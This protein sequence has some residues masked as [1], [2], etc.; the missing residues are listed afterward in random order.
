MTKMNLDKAKQMRKEYYLDDISPQILVKKYDIKT[1][2]IYRILNNKFYK[3]DEE[4]IQYYI[5]LKKTTKIC[6]GCSKRKN[7]IEFKNH[8]NK[9]IICQ[10]EY[11]KNLYNKIKNV[12]Y[13][14]LKYEQANNIR[15]EYYF[16]KINHE[17]LSHKYDISKT[18]ISA[19]VNNHY[20][21]M[22]NKDFDYFFENSLKFF[23]KYSKDIKKC[24]DCNIKYIINNFYSDYRCYNCHCQFRRQKYHK[25]KVIKPIYSDLISCSD[26]LKNK[27]LKSRV[28]SVIRNSLTRIKISKI[29]NEILSHLPFT[30]SELKQH[31]ENQ[32]EF[33]MTWQNWKR[34]NPTTWN[35]NDPSTWVWNLDHIIP[36]STFFYTSVKEYAFQQ[37]WGLNN[38]RPYSAK[39]NLIDGSRRTRHKVALNVPL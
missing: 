4:I 2:Q 24:Y 38:L 1:S 10:K 8:N 23:N 33:W 32:F 18:M 39:Q 37:C 14:I 26:K 27:I 29:N 5:N 17:I 31:I 30:I 16:N 22:K 36:Q 35:D 15:Y 34:Y 13:E 19:I 28:S 6:K 21:I 11:K 20:H 3:E 9:C 12:S 7:K 25:T